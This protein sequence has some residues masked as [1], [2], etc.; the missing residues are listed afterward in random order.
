LRVVMQRKNLQVLT[1]KIW[2]KKKWNTGKEEDCDSYDN[3]KRG[4]HRDFLAD[5]E[6]MLKQKKSMNGK[7]RHS[8]DGNTFIS[9]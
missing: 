3:I 9:M 6:M 4:K 1:K 2:R 7:H 8:H 5:F